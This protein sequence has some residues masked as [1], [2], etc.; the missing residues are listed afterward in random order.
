MLAMRAS[1]SEGFRGAIDP[2]LLASGV[3]PFVKGGL[4]REERKASVL[5]VEI[6]KGAGEGVGMISAGLDGAACGCE[7]SDIRTSSFIATS[8]VAEGVAGP[9][10][11]GDRPSTLRKSRSSTACANR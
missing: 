8:V 5:A 3:R 4:L 9:V 2:K 7:L 11:I 6:G 1:R 10:G